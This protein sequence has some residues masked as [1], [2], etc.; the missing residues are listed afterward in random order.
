[1]NDD[2]G[3]IEASLARCDEATPSAALAAA[4]EWLFADGRS[5]ERVDRCRR[6]A[7]SVGGS[8]VTGELARVWI[9]DGLNRESRAVVG[10]RERARTEVERRVAARALG[11]ADAA[12]AAL[13]C[14]PEV[15][16]VAPVR[17]G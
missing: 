15:V 10:V 3:A 1:L 17:P 13:V 4:R 14:G 7:V 6:F 8:V 12:V 16:L 9:A 2:W 11:L 5:L